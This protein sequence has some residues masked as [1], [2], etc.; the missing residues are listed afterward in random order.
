[1]CIRDRLKVPDCVRL[2]A[3]GSNEVAGIVPDIAIGWQRGDAAAA[4]ATL[5]TAALADWATS[6]FKN[7]SCD[8]V[9]SFRA[10]LALLELT[11]GVLVTEL[12]AV[13]MC[14]LLQAHWPICRV[15]S[16]SVLAVFMTSTLF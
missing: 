5:A 16:S 6:N 3:D 12:T 8:A 11:V 7:R 9:A 10:V 4:R 2:R 15:L 14:R 13:V 1:M